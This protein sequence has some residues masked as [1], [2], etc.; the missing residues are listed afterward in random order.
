MIDNLM[1]LAASMVIAIYV[2]GVIVRRSTLWYEWLAVLAGVAFA[3]WFWY[4]E[5]QR[6]KR[7]RSRPKD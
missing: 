3:C 5:W 6:A 7:R 2:I 4:A 1:P